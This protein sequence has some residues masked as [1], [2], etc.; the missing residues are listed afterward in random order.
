MNKLARRS[1]V[2]A[3]VFALG[4]AGIGVASAATGT[5]STSFTMQRST[6]AVKA[7][8]LAGVHADVKI[9]SLGSV[10]QMTIKAAKLPKNTGFDLFVIQSPNA[11]FGLSWYQGDLHTDKSG[12]LS[13]KFLGR[14]SV[15]TFTV[16]PGATA[17]PST[18]PADATINPATPPV[19]QYH[20]GIWFNSPKDAQKAGCGNA[21]TPFNG[22][23]HAG[24]QALSTRQFPQ[25]AG[26]LARID[27]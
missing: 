8:C 21:V 10:E 2:V 16:A 23:H 14:F 12:N 3:G 1:A 7:H 18:H 27:S 15:E 26:P 6:A 24:V 20:L 17:A 9:K 19:H 22:E 4:A 5:S 11:P 25:L 13:G